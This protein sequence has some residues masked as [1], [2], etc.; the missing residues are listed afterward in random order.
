MKVSR[1]RTL[2]MTLLGIALLA[3][4]LLIVGLPRVELDPGVPFAQI[5]QF[6]IEQFS[7]G[8]PVIPYA[9]GAPDGSLL[10]RIY[11]AIFLIALAV[12]P[13]AVILVMIDPELRKRVLR[14]MIRILLI[15][16]LLMLVMRN[17]VEPEEMSF[18]PEGGA[19]TPGGGL[20]GEAFSPE[21]F[22]PDRISPWV[23]R[24]LSL[25]LGV[26]AAAILVIIILRARQNRLEAESALDGI[27][28]HAR[29]ALQDI[30]QGGDLRNVVLRCYEQMTR[31]VRE[32]RGL[33]RERTVTA[34]EFVDYLTNA[35]LPEEPVTRLTGL[36]EKARYSS[37]ETTPDDEEE[38]I[39]SLRA[40]VRACEE[41]AT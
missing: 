4:L 35:K 23:G 27:A 9:V 41:L 12:F 36:F 1:S 32:Q 39:A 20:L 25:A 31:T 14:S 6:L 16:L 11:R 30:E 28:L 15:M 34:R 22:A 19:Q 18:E 2:R 17:Q 40:I 7:T 13:F 33:R 37:R 24:G 38:A 8:R 3:M 5:W 10:L 29:S 21:A 26:L